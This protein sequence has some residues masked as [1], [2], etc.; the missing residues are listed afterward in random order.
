MSRKRPTPPEP[1]IP[2]LPH[3]PE[4]PE[5]ERFVLGGALAYP[6]QLPEMLAM[7][8]PD[9]FSAERNKRICRAL[10]DL[11]ERGETVNR[12][13]VANELSRKQQLESVGGLSYIVSLDE[14]MPRLSNLESLCAIVREKAT[15]RR[16]ILAARELMQR[17]FA[18][19][20][21]AEVAV[22]AER[23]IELLQSG[24][25]PGIRALS[26]GEIQDREGGINRFLS[27]DNQRG[28]EIP[29]ATMNRTLGG[30]RRSRLIT[31][32]ARPA[33]GKS[34]LAYQWAEYAAEQGSR[35]LLV[36]L[37]MADRDLLYR[38]ITG[39]ARV[40]AYK[41][42]LGELNQTERW[43]VNTAWNEIVELG[44]RL[45]ICDRTDITVQGIAALVRSLAARNKKPD[46]LFVDYLQL[47][48]AVGRFENTYALVSYQI[49][50]LHLIGKQFDIP[51]VALSQLSRDSEKT[52]REPQLS[53]LRDSG[54]IESE[55][56]QVVFLWAK[57]DALS[58]VEPIRTVRWKVAKNRDGMLNRGELQ[59]ERKY[60][61]FLPEQ[62]VPAREIA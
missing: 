40:S 7:I 3:L 34:A 50:Q 31:L 2:E 29:F 4:A 30:L 42:R 10:A 55:S 53:D 56:H 21:T 33:V 45:L 32:A 8:S 47:L 39:R 62:A 12:V 54:A 26:P 5:A 13:T 41:F 14:G 23:I 57:D 44:D 20:N 15:L 18:Q 49:R 36:L 58:E 6:E 17:C 19:E 27:P 1:A 48:P 25:K 61:R 38:A 37:E 51:V 60:A 28:I 52:G 46:V 9:D 35:A 16:A 24:S 22:D 59:F 43:N 11:H